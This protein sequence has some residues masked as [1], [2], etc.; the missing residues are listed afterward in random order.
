MVSP[1]GFFMQELHIQS[2]KSNKNDEK[3]NLK[4]IID[5][6]LVLWF[7]LLPHHLIYSLKN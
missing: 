5:K 3:I 1:T 4:K 6:K 2:K 7:F